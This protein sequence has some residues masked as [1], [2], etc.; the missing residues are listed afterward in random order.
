VWGV[1]R[2]GPILAV[3]V[4]VLAVPFWGKAFHIDDPFFIAVA[5][6]VRRDPLR[7]FGGAVALDDTDHRVFGR[8]RAAP[9]TFET[10]SHPPLVPYVIAAAAL[11]S[12][13]IHETAE[14]AAFLVF[15]ALAA[16][17]QYRLARRFTAA[18][19]W[20]TVVF[21]ACP[22]VVLAGHGLMTDLPSLALALAA[23]ALFVEGLD[24]DDARRLVLAGVLAGAAMLARYV[25]LGLVPLLALYAL[26]RPRRARAWIALLP[27]FLV[28]AAWLLQNRL[29]HGA[30]HLTAGARHYAQYYEGRYLTMGDLG[31]RALA[32]LAALGGTLL[33]LAVLVARRDRSRR[34]WW[35]LASYAAL[36][37]ASVLVASRALPELR[38]YGPVETATLALF[39]GAALLLLDRAVAAGLGDAEG[40]WLVAWMTVGLVCTVVLLPF[41][42]ARYLLPVLPPLVLL[43]ARRGEA[44]GDPVRPGAWAAAA[45]IAALSVALAVADQQYAG[46]YREVAGSVTRPAGERNVWFIGDWGFRYYMERAGHR[47]LLS[48]SETPVAGDLVIRPQ[49]AGLHEM[50]PG[51]AARTE[52]LA[53]IE[54]PGGWPVR[55]MSHEARAGYYSHGWGLL[56]FAFSRAPL[57]RFDV[58]RVA[59]PPS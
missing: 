20:A 53:T 31:R 23:I 9:N 43:C 25:W 15:P 40:R 18:P 44:N 19:L 22:V 51:L 26:G 27:F 21:A 35:R 3:V 46:A 32:D 2:A 42:A 38:D 54:I 1:R 59:G 10:L 24:E 47:Y 16:W 30:F 50:A 14:H 56:P 11:P 39:V 29:V 8:L 58:F 12:G 28:L 17:A 45:A 37:G 49:I 36:A 6:N 52:R 13:G 41:G 57:E 55:L 34:A 4:A 5:E 48:T 7:P 33:P